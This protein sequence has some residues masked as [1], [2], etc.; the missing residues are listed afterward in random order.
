MTFY[1]SV[2]PPQNDAWIKIG[3]ISPEQ[4]CLEGHNGISILEI[5]TEQYSETRYLKVV[6]EAPGDNVDGLYCT[7]TK[8]AVYGQS[9]Y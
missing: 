1:G 2:E 9:G 3:S 5:G 7:I 4:S 8:V 6:M